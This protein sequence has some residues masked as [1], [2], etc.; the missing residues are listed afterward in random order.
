MSSGAPRAAGPGEPSDASL[1]PEAQAVIADAIQRAAG[2]E[3]FFF[4]SLDEAGRVATVEVV[5]RGHRGAVPVFL[6]R[7]GSHQVLIHN[8]PGGD[9]TPSPADLNVASEAGVRGLGFFIVDNAARRV[10][11]AVEPFTPPAQT[12]IDSQEVDQIFAPGGLLALALPGYEPRDGQR[13]LARQV[14]QSFERGEVAALEAG[15]GVGKSFAYLVPAILWAVRNRSRVVISTQTIALQEQLV[16]KDLPTLARVLPESFVFTLVKGRSNYLCRRK[17]SEVRREPDLFGDE[18][19]PTRWRREILDRLDS[20]R[21]GSLSELPGV[22]PDAVWQ[23]FASTTDQSLKVRCPHYSQCFY[24]NARRRAATAHIVVVNHHLFFA[25]LAVRRSLGLQEG[26]LVIPGY[27]RVIFDEAHRLEEVAAQHFG[28]QVSRLG[29]LQMLG[30]MLAPPARLGAPA[31]GRLAYLSHVLMRHD[32]E[33]AHAHLES[34]LAP[35]IGLARRH[36]EEAFSELRERFEAWA[37]GRREAANGV[38]SSGVSSRAESSRALSPASAV[39]IGE[40]ETDL[41]VTI[42]AGPLADL[43]LELAELARI[44]RAGRNLLVRHPFQPE[45][46]HEA[47]LA[48][49][50]ALLHRVEEQAQAIERF[51]STPAN[52]LPWIELDASARRNLVCRAAPVRVGGVLAETLYTPLDSVVMTS[53]TLSVDGGWDFLGDRLGWHEIE[54][55]RFVG[56][57]FP[58]PFDYQAQVIL[59]LPTDLPEPD[60]RGHLEVLEEVITDT[61]RA[62]RGRTFVL[63]T[64]HHALQTLARR[65]R[66]ALEAAGLPVMVQG[67]APRGALLDRFRAAGNAV[68]FGNQTFWEGVD[69]PGEALSCVIITRLPF[70]VPTHPLERGRAAEV[71]ARGKNP[72]RDLTVPEAALA[73]K[74]GFGRLVRTTTDRGVVVI[75]D[76]RLLSRPYGRVLLRSLP[77]CRRLEGPWDTVRAGIE[78]AFLERAP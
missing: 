59:A 76:S 48:E 29:M 70:K 57:S 1:T 64:A 34:D 15:T 7:A 27:R 75:A 50:T 73:L 69:V 30:R 6:E 62:A 36:V 39:G 14:A 26:D 66:G 53:A 63:F 23:D 45:V 58:S 72:F 47:A 22:P 68:L 71:S 9:L 10:L 13:Q 19:E 28:V 46:E 60:R 77:E 44:V 25:D 31:R 3:V 42:I 21:E 67:E 38:V 52:L 65:C 2:N 20:L 74:Q 49:Y 40:A 12:V 78:Q 43:R 51:L 37:A 32:A 17:A 4:G 35:A 16:N 61:A 5:A 55:G 56:N 54:R 11:R 18:A 33:E 41:P 8:H 24:Y